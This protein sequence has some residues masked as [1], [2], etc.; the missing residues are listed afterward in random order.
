MIGHGR[1]LVVIV[2][3][4]VIDLAADL[5]AEHVIAEQA[6][7]S[8][9][10]TDS[11]VKDTA[12]IDVEHEAVR[13]EHVTERR[14]HGVGASR[15]HLHD[16]RAIRR[17]QRQHWLAL[18]GALCNT[19]SDNAIA[20]CFILMNFERKRTTP[21]DITVTWFARVAHVVRV[22]A[23]AFAAT[24]PVGKTKASLW[25]CSCTCSGSHCCCCF[26]G[27]FLLALATQIGSVGDAEQLFDLVE[28]GSPL[29]GY[30]HGLGRRD[31][32]A[33]CHEVHAHVGDAWLGRLV[34]VLDEL[35]CSRCNVDRVRHLLARFE[36]AFE[37][38]HVG[39]EFFR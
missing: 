30:H 32:E 23:R 39:V 24:L 18:P 16:H 33:R 5:R 6:V 15:G 13:G 22:D 11:R 19:I 26:L 3:G 21:S 8:V 35:Q 14:R 20:L 7:A 34:R 28:R 37:R 12:T 1:G 10:F 29:V 4:L 2:T 36:L 9:I 25:I 38:A 17:L 31:A 27:S